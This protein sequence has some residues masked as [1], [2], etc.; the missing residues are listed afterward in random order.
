MTAKDLQRKI[1]GLK[2]I[3]F[4]YRA[5]I[6]LLPRDCLKLTY[7]QTPAPD[8]TT[9]LGKTYYKFGHDPI[10]NG[11]YY[12][13]ENCGSDQYVLVENMRRLLAKVNMFHGLIKIREE[14]LGGME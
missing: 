7:Y 2:Y 4:S 13:M 9:F 3:M 8:V 6:T 1:A 5:K 10:S 11:H 14:I 12:M